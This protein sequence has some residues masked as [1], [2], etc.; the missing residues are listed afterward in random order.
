MIWRQYPLDVSCRGRG[1]YDITGLI[2]DKVR[3]S[4]AR[5]GLAHVF[6]QHTSASLMICENADPAVRGDLETLMARLVPD[7]DP[8]FRHRSEGPDDMA[9]HAR[10][11]LT[12]TELTVPVVNGQ[13]GLGTWQGI[14]VWEHRQDSFVRHIVVTIHGE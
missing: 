2:E 11:V 1:S 14:Y 6:V 3:Q 4:G 10:T 5:T 9:A 7:G 8:A 13:L 12:A